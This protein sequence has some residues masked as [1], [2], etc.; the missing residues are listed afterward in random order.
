MEVPMLNAKYRRA[1]PLQAKSASLANPERRAF[2]THGG[3]YFVAL[4]ITA[5]LPLA[6]VSG[7]ATA[8]QIAAD[9]TRIRAKR[10]AVD[11]QWGKLDCYFASPKADTAPLPAVIVAHDKLGLTPH[12]EDVARRL[13]IEGFI[14]LAPDYA[15][16]FGGT[17]S[18]SGPAL[19]V[20]GMTKTV[21]MVSDT[22]TALLWLK[23]NTTSSEKIGAVGFGWGATAIDYAITRLPDLKAAAIFYGHPPPVA[24]LGNI[25]APLML[26]FASKDQ[27]VGPEI[28][29]LVDALKKAGVKY[30]MFVYD[31]TEPGFDDETARTR[32]SAEAAKLAWS[33]TVGFL[34]AALS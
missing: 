27:F 26:N 21:D 19:E 29:G 6:L 5:A 20:V 24:D 2:L 4:S 11:A 28:P 1:L 33:R 22:E 14:A 15:S 16:R 30:E 17:P 13:A 3:S 7:Q 18:E 8:A 23:A 31:N 32:Y 25:K 10:V 12:F 34:K 9:D